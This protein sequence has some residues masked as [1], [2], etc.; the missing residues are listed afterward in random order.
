[1]VD[2][3]LRSVA[4]L[5]H[6]TAA[7]WTADHRKGQSMSRHS[8]L[9]VIVVMFAFAGSALALSPTGS[10]DCDAFIDTPHFRVH[11]STLTGNQPPG[12]PDL[13]VVDNLGSYLE[14]TYAY[15]RD[16]SGMGVPLP[17][18]AFG[19]GQDLVDC[20]FWPSGGLGFAVGGGLAAGACAGAMWGYIDIATDM[21]ETIFDDELRA[22]SAHEF[23]HL[24]Q[25]SRGIHGGGWFMESTAMA[26]EFLIWPEESSPRGFG[27]W[28][29]HTWYPIWDQSGM[30]RYSP[31]FWFFLMAKFDDGV[32]TRICDR[33]C[34]MSTE[35]AIRAELTTLGT[36]L[37]AVTAEFAVWN[38]FTGERDDGHHYNPVYGLKSINFTDAFTALPVPP[39]RPSGGHYARPAGTN[40]IG[41]SGRATRA[42]LRVHFD[43]APE[44]SAGRS[45]SIVAA[46][47]HGHREWTLTPD[48]DGDA[49]F[50]VPDWDLYDEVALVVAN[51]WDAPADSA[52]L[53][54]EFSAEEIDGEPVLP[55]P[56]ELVK[57]SPNPFT[58]A[59]EVQFLVP[60][61]GL[62][63]SV[64]IYDAAGRRVRTLDD[65]RVYAG[66]RR[67]AWDGR[68]DQGR[69][70]AAGPYLI[71]LET[72][73]HVQSRKVMLV[74]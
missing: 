48:L 60:D 41:F 32:M 51:F 21:N 44:L 35:T 43:G 17:D 56:G 47:S 13:T 69:R 15:H 29:L 20:Y 22:T 72:G 3:R 36:D 53:D 67:A 14:T 74:D 18:G 42:D 31:H 62:P 10:G 16:V 6:T 33:T 11:Y 8:H 61:T 65:A 25:Y 46:N 34:E 37:D 71:R 38:Y 63:A 64:R 2:G 4:L 59:T 19:G 52:L 49:D 23:Y 24:L 40:Y 30:Q 5:Y 27:E 1:M 68:D 54:Y 12:Y 28:T 73:G 70:V 26:S 7:D 45:V 55:T 39:R 58:D 9:F 50:R 57:A 66:M